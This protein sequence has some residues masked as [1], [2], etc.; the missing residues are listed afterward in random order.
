MAGLFAIR[1]HPLRRRPQSSKLS[2][3]R[4]SSQRATSASGQGQRLTKSDSDKGAA[5]IPIDAQPLG[6]MASEEPPDGTTERTSDPLPL[7]GPAA[8]CGS[9]RAPETSFEPWSATKRI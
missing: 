7:A 4:A 9:R 8:G 2:L 5:N 1:T 6:H 3:I